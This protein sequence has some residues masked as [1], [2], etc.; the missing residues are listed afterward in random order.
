MI[1]KDALNI[2]RIRTLN[3]DNKTYSVSDYDLY[4]QIT[5]T[6]KVYGINKSLTQYRRHSN[7]LSGA[8][9]GTSADLE[10]L[11][12]DYK[13]NN[14]INNALYNKKMSWI[15]IVYAVFSLES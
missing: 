11:I 5:N 9:G 15:Y 6:N 3:P 14:L 7:N 13:K 12:N 4:F 10:L 1:H 8:S 2:D